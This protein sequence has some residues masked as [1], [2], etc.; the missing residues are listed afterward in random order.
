[1][2]AFSVRLFCCS[3]RGKGGCPARSVGRRGCSAR[4][5]WERATGT[6]LVARTMCRGE[7]DPYVAAF[8][9]S[10]GNAG[11]PVRRTREP[12]ERCL[13]GG[14]LQ[15]RGSVCQRVL[16][17]PEA[18]VRRGSRW[19]ATWRRGKQS[20]SPDWKTR[21]SS[22]RDALYPLEGREWS[23]HRRRRTRAVRTERPVRAATRYTPVGTDRPR[24]SSPFHRN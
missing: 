13:P 9:G 4:R 1:M 21:R 10:K 16:F 14:Y 19:A 8:S 3:A 15:T 11:T 5:H 6:G 24:A 12:L 17:F 23:A 2:G 7:P 20:R 22:R 18:K